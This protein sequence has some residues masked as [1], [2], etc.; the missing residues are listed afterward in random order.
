E[1]TSLSEPWNAVSETVTS[2]DR[3]DI[4]AEA[5]PAPVAAEAISVFEPT[6]SIESSEPRVLEEP[7]AEFEAAV[8][9]QTEQETRKPEVQ[10]AF[11]VKPPSDG[12][13]ASN[14][15]GFRALLQ[16][17]RREQAAREAAEQ[18]SKEQQ[19]LENEARTIPPEEEIEW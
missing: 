17:S 4:P 10:I 13:E 8:E 3:V 16:S 18:S 12:A 6:S 11:A 5:E 7:E 15:V 9:Q 1:Q 2:Q 14:D 19:E